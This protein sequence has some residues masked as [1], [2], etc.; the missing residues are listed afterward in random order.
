M[1]PF[2]RLN[3]RLKEGYEQRALRRTPGKADLWIQAASVGESLLALE[4]IK[5]I[6]SE[7]PLTVLITSNTSQGIR[8][9]NDRVKPLV[10]KHGPI[11]IS[12]AYFPFDKPS[13]MKEAI[14][15]IRPRVMVLLEAELWPGLLAGL[16]KTACKILLINGRITVKSLLF[17]LKWPALWRSLR[18]DHILAISE[19]DAARYRKLFDFS[20]I[21][22]MD[23]IKFDRIKPDERTVTGHESILNILPRHHRFLVFGSIRQ[24]EESRV[25]KIITTVLRQIP[26]LVIGLFPRHVHRTGQWK[27][28]LERLNVAWE[29]RSG[30]NNRVKPGTVVIWDTFGE[31]DPAYG[32]ADASFIGGSLAP[33]GGQNFLEP[34]KYGI[35]PV[36]G[37][38][39]ENFSWVG[40]QIVE[41]ELL[42]V[43]PNWEEAARALIGQLSQKRSKREIRE[44]AALYFKNRQGGTLT[45]VKLIQ[46]Y[47]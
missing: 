30:L 2:L 32:H 15:L 28:R 35:V 12:V 38:S 19:N 10:S 26:D 34:L 23:N 43:V 8:I 18:P 1:M 39:W 31:L 44:K 21:D 22:T 41:Q 29:L 3:H 27:E 33:L 5:T 7:R 45:A 13:L 37:P 14:Q 40:R 9:L 16:K 47:L 4:L 6:K 20:G 46:D 42:Y 17:Y 25:G 36:I 11:H 24:E